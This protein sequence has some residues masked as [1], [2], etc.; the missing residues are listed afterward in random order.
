MFVKGGTPSAPSSPEDEAKHKVRLSS[1]SIT[2]FYY[3]TMMFQVY[4]SPKPFNTT[5]LQVEILE[6]ELGELR[7]QLQETES[8][9]VYLSAIVD[10]QKKSVY[11]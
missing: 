6:K 2:L 4:S 8:R 11:P 3:K 10:E 9:N 7:L 1:Y 5:P